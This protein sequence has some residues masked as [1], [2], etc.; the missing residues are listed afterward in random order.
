MI[1]IEREINDKAEFLMIGE[2]STSY[3]CPLVI[4]DITEW[5]G[6]ILIDTKQIRNRYLV[7]DKNNFQEKVKKFIGEN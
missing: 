1:D 2:K 5:E 4:E 7:F 3:K 6:K